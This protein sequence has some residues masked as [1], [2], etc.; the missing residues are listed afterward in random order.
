MF[1]HNNKV[2]AQH[3]KNRMNQ[4]NRV[5]RG[6]SGSMGSGQLSGVSALQDDND[7][8]E[9]VSSGLGYYN[10]YQG[11]DNI[12]DY[13]KAAKRT[14]GGHSLAERIRMEEEASS[15]DFGSLEGEGEEEATSPSPPTKSSP[16]KASSIT[17]TK[18]SEEIDSSATRPATT[19]DG[20]LSSA[21]NKEHTP[22]EPRDSNAA[23]NWAKIRLA[24]KMA[25]AFK[26]V[27]ED[28]QK[29]GANAND[30]HIDWKEVYK[31]ND[32]G[33][34]MND[35]GKWV[36]DPHGSFR[37]SWDIFMSFILLYIAFY[38]P[39]RVCLYWDDDATTSGMQVL[40][41]GSDVL[42]G[43]DII[44]NFFTAYHDR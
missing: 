16:P 20:K 25:V 13:T 5:R 21:M 28:I 4:N 27:N 3:S 42:F 35:A 24:N 8:N 30:E 34:A 33:K 15:Q 37:I 23:K 39:Y 26:G 14:G 22:I 7:R 18:A 40:E 31:G 41:Y 36:I 32:K 17:P 38:V 43:I 11:D 19:P 10:S 12:T 2:Q 29:F 6:S 44:L 1:A 9:D